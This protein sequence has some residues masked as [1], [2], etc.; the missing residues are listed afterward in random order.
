MKSLYVFTMVVFVYAAVGAAESRAQEA[1]ASAAAEQQESAPESQAPI[2]REVPDT[3]MFSIDDLNDIQSRIA[4]G[5]D[6][7]RD[8]SAI[9]EAT[10]YLSTILYYGPNDWTIWINGLPINPGENFRS[11]QVTDIGPSHVDLLVPLSAQGMR[12]VRL[13]PNQTF[14]TSS[15]TIVEGPWEG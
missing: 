15:G 12:P 8:D 7:D 4:G 1:S 3:L 2:S 6:G 11:F 13:A 10:L 9:E 14:I 5:S